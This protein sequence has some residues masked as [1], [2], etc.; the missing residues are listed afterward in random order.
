M[1]TI[2]IL[3]VKRDTHYSNFVIII[4]RDI[5]HVYVSSHYI[6]KTKQSHTTYAL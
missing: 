3:Q 2:L 4:F 6:G 1:V 5:K